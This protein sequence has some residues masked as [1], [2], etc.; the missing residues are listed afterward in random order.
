MPVGDIGVSAVVLV[1]D[2]DFQSEKVGLKML[3][4]SGSLF[5]IYI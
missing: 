3:G 2:D 5:C 1:Q 4:A